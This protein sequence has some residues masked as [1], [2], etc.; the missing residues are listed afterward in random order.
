MKFIFRIV[1]AFSLT[2]TMAGCMDTNMEDEHPRLSEIS[3]GMNQSEVRSILG[4]PFENA[5]HPDIQHFCDTFQYPTSDGPKHSHVRY[6]VD[7]VESVVTNRNY[8]CF[9]TDPDGEVQRIN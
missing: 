6:D 4:E 7:I 1:L 9:L 8:V 2:Q 3:V 5:T